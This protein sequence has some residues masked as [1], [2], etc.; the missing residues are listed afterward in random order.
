MENV[1]LFLICVPILHSI[2]KKTSKPIFIM[3][4]SQL[5]Q[6]KGRNIY[7]V[8]ADISVFEALKVMGEKNIGA[9]LVI[10][11]D[12]LKGIISERDYARKVVLKNRTS[13]DTLVKEIMTE[14][15]ITVTPTNTIE[16]CMALM[17]DKHIRH[18][19]VVEGSKVVGIISV[20]DIVTSIIN[21]QQNVIQQLH[22]YI[23]N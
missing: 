23:T 4:V 8:V 18:L 16:E 22:S 11:N 9:L 12:V 2:S 3:I 17:S 21:E 7:S 15:V 1:K 5:L 19:P 10:E 13:R 14:K 20:S 6:N